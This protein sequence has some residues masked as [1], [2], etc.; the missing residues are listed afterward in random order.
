MRSASSSRLSRSV[1][2]P[3]ALLG[4]SGLLL[5]GCGAAPEQSG[6][7]NGSSPAADNSDYKAC[8]VSDQ[9]G[10]D[11]RSFNQSSYEGVTAAKDELGIEMAQ[12]ESNSP[13]SS[14]P[15]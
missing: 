8:I 13:R 14:L 6:S 15:T 9:G 10:F 11:D 3:A 2:V 4:V 12:A 1:G 7:G 5:A